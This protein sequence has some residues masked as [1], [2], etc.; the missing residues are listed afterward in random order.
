MFLAVFYSTS[1]RA[2]AKSARRD[3]IIYTEWLRDGQEEQDTLDTSVT[4]YDVDFRFFFS[5]F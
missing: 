1:V 5:L 4:T 2:I 3:I